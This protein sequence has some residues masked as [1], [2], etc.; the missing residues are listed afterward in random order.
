MANRSWREGYAVSQSLIHP[1]WSTEVGHQFARVPG[2]ATLANSATIIFEIGF[3][4]A[5]L[6]FFHRPRR[7]RLALA[8]GLAGMGLHLGITL[9][10]DIGLFGVQPLLTL[11]V[12]IPAVAVGRL[13]MVPAVAVSLIPFKGKLGRWHQAKITGLRTRHARWDRESEDA[14][15]SETAAFRRVT[16]ILVAPFILS[17]VIVQQPVRG[18]IDKSIVEGLSPATTTVALSTYRCFAT[19]L[20]VIGDERPHNVFSQYSQG[21]CFTFETLIRNEDETADGSN[22]LFNSDGERVQFTRYMRNFMLWYVLGQ[23]MAWHTLE[24]GRIPDTWHEEFEKI[25]S[26]LLRRRMADETPGSI[27]EVDFFYHAWRVPEEG[28]A[29][30]KIEPTPRRRL[31]TVWIRRTTQREIQLRFIYHDVGV[32]PISPTTSKP[33]LDS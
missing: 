6:P 17:A 16:L 1:Q 12:F 10:Y 23:R 24:T 22:L 21:A 13:A 27:R 33:S 11:I 9:C 15:P 18:L 31:A 29:G 30:R 3:L 5:L 26:P 2:F 7:A 28:P 25:A 20:R 19:L 14:I 32:L 4:F 8:I